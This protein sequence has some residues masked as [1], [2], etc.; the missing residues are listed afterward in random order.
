M[1]F[2]APLVVTNVHLP[3]YTMANITYNFILDAGMLAYR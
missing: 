1:L 2:S 3:D